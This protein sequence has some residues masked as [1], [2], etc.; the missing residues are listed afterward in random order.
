MKKIQCQNCNKTN[1]IEI[2]FFGYHPTVNDFKSNTDKDE[3]TNYFP[4]DLYYC[5]SCELIQIGTQI[6]SSII[7]PKNYSYRSG[8][9]NILKKNFKDLLNQINKFKLIKKNELIVDIGSNDGTLLEN[10]KNNYRICGI[11]PTDV[12]KLALARGIKTINSPINDKVANYIIA[13]YGKAKI[14]T[15]ANVF[16]HIQNVN[17][18]IKVIKKMLKPNGVFIS[19]NTYAMSLFSSL[20]YD[21]VYHEHLRYYT[22]RSLIKIFHKNNLEI[23]RVEK[24]PTHGGSIRVYTSYKG[25]FSIHKSVKNMLNKEFNKKEMIKN[26]KL[27]NKK[28][29]VSKYKILQTVLN[30]KLKGKSI[31][32]ISA[33]SRASTLINFLGLDHKMIDYICEIKGSLK[34][35]KFIPGTKIP[36]VNEEK[37]YFD[38]PDF[39]IVFSWHIADELINKIRARGFKGKFLIPLPFPKIVN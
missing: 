11:E 8:T 10:F 28:Y 24:I 27:I 36:V 30:I 29:E 5:K 20:Q 18:I 21:T 33:P 3:I 37:M 12:Y 34:I 31:V 16:A 22:L 7:F 23:F 26:I 19:E 38:N 25:K 32:G 1:L 4:L 2:Y 17:Q 13:K 6:E 14:I 9:T 39:A 15:A 35:G